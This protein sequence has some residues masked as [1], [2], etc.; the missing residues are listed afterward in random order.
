MKHP[1][2]SQLIDTLLEG[3][4]DLE[5]R[6]HLGNCPA[7]SERLRRLESVRESLMGEEVL[8]CD[9]ETSEEIFSKVWDESREG[10]SSRPGG[11]GW[12]RW[13][14]QP[15]G[16]FLAGLFLGYVLFAD[17]NRTDKTEV[18]RDS[19]NPTT[20]RSKETGIQREELEIDYWE[21]AGFRNAK[22]TPTVRYEGGRQVMGGQLEAETAGGAL[23]VMNY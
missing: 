4:V 5:I 20:D 21:K 18:P 6:Q 2:D 23:V 1:S 16:I 8:K 19:P 12:W 14:V 22:F 7:C 9:P 13:G 3:S 10:V 17:P 11:L 15:A